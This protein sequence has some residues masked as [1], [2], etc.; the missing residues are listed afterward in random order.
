M[1]IVII[2]S[3]YGEEI[4]E[5]TCEFDKDTDVDELLGFATNGGA[6]RIP[7]EEDRKLWNK[8]IDEKWG[9]LDDGGRIITTSP[10]D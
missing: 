6:F 7:H 5:D 3:K 10:K 9:R 8:I 4:I 2:A 1:A